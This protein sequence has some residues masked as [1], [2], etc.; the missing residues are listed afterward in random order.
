MNAV[1]S[2]GSLASSHLL[3]LASKGKPAQENP[4]W[5]LRQCMALWLVSV[6]GL[7]LE[8]KFPHF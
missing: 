4:T 2:P 5:S 8:I 3:S 7:E 1:L 6:A